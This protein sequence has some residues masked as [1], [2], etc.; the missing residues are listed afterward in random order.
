MESFLPTIKYKYARKAEQNYEVSSYGDTRFSPLVAKL[1]DGRT[2]EEAYQLDIKGYRKLGNNWKLGKGKPPMIPVNNLPKITS[3]YFEIKNNKFNIFQDLIDLSNCCSKLI[4]ND[5]RNST[6]REFIRIVKAEHKDKVNSLSYDN[7][8][9]VLVLIDESTKEIN[10][11][12]YVEAI[13][14][15]YSAGTVGVLSFVTIPTE[16]VLMTNFYETLKN[17]INQKYDSITGTN[18][19]IN[20]YGQYLGLWTQW[21]I[22]NPSL[23]RE[24]AILS[25]DK[26]LTD[27]YATT[28]ISQARALCDIL[29][30]MYNL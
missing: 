9:I 18:Y 10:Y 11:N 15:L 5:V 12:S 19:F 3:H 17:I 20:L 26:V 7:E 14:S 16:E 13:D 28:K 2:I 25:H 8:D 30:K 22:E 6:I 1:S 29:N 21:T 27:I 24:L 4:C 23:I